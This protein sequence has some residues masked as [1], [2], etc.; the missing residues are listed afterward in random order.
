MQ[1]VFS[2]MDLNERLKTPL[3][4][5]EIERVCNLAQERGFDSLD[6]EKT[7][8]AKK[9]GFVNAG[10]NYSSGS[11]YY[12]FDVKDEELPHLKTITKP[13]STTNPQ[14]VPKE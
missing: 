2:T 3:S 11:L 6:E 14:G 7:T 12:K 8:Q 4:F 13:Q 5:P 9:R 1:A 10:L